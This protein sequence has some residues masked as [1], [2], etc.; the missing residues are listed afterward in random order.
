MGAQ[1]WVPP[2]DVAAEADDIAPAY[3]RLDGDRLRDV[4]ARV[5]V[6]FPTLLAL[7]ASSCGGRVQS[8]AEQLAHR[9]GETESK[10]SAVVL[11]AAGVTDPCNTTC[12]GLLTEVD[13]LPLVAAV[14][15]PTVSGAER[16]DGQAWVDCPEPDGHEVMD[17]GGPLLA[18]ALSSKGMVLRESD[19]KGWLRNPV[20]VADG[21]PDGMYAVVDEA[22]LTAVLDVY[23][24]EGGECYSRVAGSWMPDPGR[25]EA[26][27]AAGLPVSRVA[28]SELRVLRRHVDDH[29]VVHRVVTADAFPGLLEAVDVTN[30]DTCPA[31]DGAGAY[32]GMECVLCDGT[33]ELNFG[34]QDDDEEEGGPSVAGLLV[35]AGDTGRILML[36]RALDEDDPAGGMWECPGG[37]IEGDEMPLE[38][39][40]REWQ[41]ETG[42]TLPDG[43]PSGTWASTNGVYQ[44]HV[45][46]V[47]DEQ[48]VPIHEGRD[49]VTNPD[50]PDGDQVEALAW[51]DPDH[52]I[53]N[54]AL[55]DELAA[56]LGLVLD[57][58]GAALPDSLVADFNPG[59]TRDVTGQWTSGGGGTGT[60]GLDKNQWL[61][62][63]AA[64]NPT[65]KGKGSSKSAANAAAKKAAATAKAAHAKARTAK[66]AA[67][68]AGVAGQI[69]QAQAD[70]QSTQK[71]F[72]DKLNAQNAAEAALALQNQNKIDLLPPNARAGP[73]KKEKARIAAY[74]AQVKDVSAAETARHNAAAVSLKQ[75]ASVAQ[76]KLASDIAAL[77][78]SAMIADAVAHTRTPD[79]LERYWVRGKGAARIKWAVSGDYDRCLRNL[80]KYVHDT[81]TLHGQCSSLHKLATGF[82]PGREHASHGG[83]K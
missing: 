68:K 12:Y 4:G 51:W 64:N 50:D 40:I 1:L 83:K 77:P 82:W 60:K 42:C 34:D 36:Q 39:A 46:E 72:T 37:H 3:P 55:R 59:E 53:D 75:Q 15:R 30:D 63:M 9:S 71:A 27:I 57:A 10:K 41:E 38:G 31:C 80:G 69:K 44:G 13:G 79:A 48:S 45:F 49:D 52:L 14:L 62:N 78:A 73:L 74:N 47:D 58:L 56:D 33:G 29:D 76:S 54:P 22:D 65:G 17:L 28:D 67:M 26:L 5:P 20:L 25:V 21:S 43:V 11:L 7:I 8:W 70:E 24:V 19:P 18:A 61:A 2:R 81:H 16:W 66:I 6:G 32:D 35:R 23:C